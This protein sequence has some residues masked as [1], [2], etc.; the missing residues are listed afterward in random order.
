MTVDRTHAPR[1][2]DP[3]SPPGGTRRPRTATAPRRSS[4]APGPRTWP[5]CRP[6]LPRRPAGSPGRLD[7]RSAD[8]SPAAAAGRSSPGAAPVLAVTVGAGYLIIGEHRRQRQAGARRL[9]TA[10]TPRPVRP[11]GTVADLPARR[12]RLA[13]GRSRPTGPTLARCR[14]RSAAPQRRAD[15]RAAERGPHRGGRR[16]DPARQLGRHPGPRAGQDQRGLR[17]RRRRRC[18]SQTVENL[19]RL[20]ID[21]FAVIDFAGFRRWSTP[22]AAS[23]WTSTPRRAATASAFHRGT[24]HLDGRAGAG[25]RP[26]ALRPLRRRPRPRPARAER[27]AGAVHPGRRAGARSPTRPAPTTCSTRRV[28]SV[29][30]DDTLSNGGLRGL[31]SNLERPRADRHHLRPRPGGGRR[32]GR[33]A[34]PSCTSTGARSARAVGTALRDDRVAA[35]ADRA[36][37]RHPGCDDPMTLADYLR[38]LRERWAIVLTRGRPRARRRRRRPGTCGRRSTPPS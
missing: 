28:R 16:L 19:T 11:P 30:V 18:S 12:H 10:S 2:A 7:A 32:A 37:R 4:S 5:T 25:V 34:R 15:D 23:T 22:S 1:T 8:S 24:N 9:R 36:P 27:A 6:S 38:I 21:H 35:Y 17:H 13:L 33:A 20:R 26:A 29:S 14:P 3:V 31:A